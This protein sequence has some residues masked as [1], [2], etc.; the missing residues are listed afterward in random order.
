M[1]R[2]VFICTLQP[3]CSRQG[4]GRQI[5]LAVIFLAGSGVGIGYV[6]G[7]LMLA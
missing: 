2:L 5:G 4:R 3:V 1:V 7:S 6:F